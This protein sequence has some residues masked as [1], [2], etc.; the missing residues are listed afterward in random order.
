M[1]VCAAGG[2]LALPGKTNVQLFQVKPRA[3]AQHLEVRRGKARVGLHEVL[4]QAG[5]RGAESRR[6]GLVIA[7]NHHRLLDALRQRQVHGGRQ[8][9]AGAVSQPFVVG[10]AVVRVQ[11]GE[12]G[13]HVRRQGIAGAVGGVALVVLRPQPVQHEAQLAPD[14]AL[15]RV[16]A[17]GRCAV[18]GRPGQRQHEIVEIAQ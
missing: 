16:T 8:P 5:D 14:G 6:R 17:A 1:H 3:R 4:L 10:Q 2:W 7:G 11:A 12:A 15:L 13:L 18:I 9:A